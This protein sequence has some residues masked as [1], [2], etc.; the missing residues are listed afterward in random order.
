MCRTTLIIQSR[1]A[2]IRA[3]IKPSI[4]KPWTKYE[5]KIK[6]KALI[7]KVNSPRVRML[8]GRVRIKIIGLIKALSIPRTRATTSAVVKLAT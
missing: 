5:A 6:R 1:K 7:T 8:I 2:A 4:L 3:G